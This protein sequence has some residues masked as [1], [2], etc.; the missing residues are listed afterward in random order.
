MDKDG[1][2]TFRVGDEDFQKLVLARMAELKLTDT[3]YIRELIKADIEGRTSI[4]KA[5]DSE[6]LIKIAETYCAPDVFD[7]FKSALADHETDQRAII[8]K[9]LES[10]TEALEDYDVYAVD[11]RLKVIPWETYDSLMSA[12]S[13]LDRFLAEAIENAAQYLDEDEKLTAEN[14]AEKLK[15]NFVCNRDGYLMPVEFEEEMDLYH[16]RSPRRIYYPSATLPTGKPMDAT[17]RKA[18]K[19]LRT[20]AVEPMSDKEIKERKTNPNAK[21]PKKKQTGS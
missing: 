21:K 19:L 15:N 14:V 5:Q 18:T 16:K 2:I 20:S 4:P 6:A 13:D 3:N 8:R 10:Y 7:R 1:K 11:A 9:L 12:I 17:M